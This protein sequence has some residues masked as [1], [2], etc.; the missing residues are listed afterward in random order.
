MRVCLGIIFLFQN[1]LPAQ[2]HSLDSLVASTAEPIAAICGD[3]Q[4]VDELLRQ[5]RVLSE[6]A[7]SGS[8]ETLADLACTR[9]RLY[10]T[11]TIARE[12]WNMPSGTSWHEGA[13][14]AT[15]AAL[16]RGASATPI[17]ELLGHLLLAEPKVDSQLTTVG[18]LRDRM[19]GGALLGSA[20][21]RG[22]VVTAARLAAWDDLERCALHG[23]Q[24][25]Q[26]STWLL[27]EVARSAFAQND[28]AGGRRFFDRAIGSARTPADW[29]AIGWHLGW[30]LEPEE[31]EAWITLADSARTAWVRDR[32]ASRDIRDGRN[33]DTRI[34]E[35]FRRLRVAD[36]A[37]R[38]T[39]PTRLLARFENAATPENLPEPADP[40]YIQLFPHG[41]RV[42]EAWYDP[43]L[44]AA[45]PFRNHRR[46]DPRYD[47]RAAV[48]L[49]MGPPVKRI[50]WA[51]RDTTRVVGRATL[52]QQ[53]QARRV[54]SPAGSMGGAVGPVEL[55]SPNA[56]I[57]REAWTY[58]IDG[59]ELLLHFEGER[60]T[61]TTEATRLV[62][63][64][65]GHYLCDIDTTRCHLSLRSQGAFEQFWRLDPR[66]QQRPPEL[67]PVPPE[68]IATIREA[69]REHLTQATT[70][71]DHGVRAARS[72]TTLARLH[73]VWDPASGEV[74]GVV[75]YAVRTGDV[76]E[77]GD[78][79]TTFTLT[80]RQWD[81]GTGAWLEAAIPRA[82]RLP[83][84]RPRDG[85]LTGH[86]VVA[87]GAGV[88][89]W[90]VVA[91][92]DTTAWGRAWADR[93]APLG[94]GALVISDVILGATSQGQRWRTTG[95]TEVPLAPLGAFD[96]NEPMTLYWQVKSTTARDDLRT[97]V[98]LYE[99][100]NK[101]EEPALQIAF[102]GRVAAGLTEELREVGIAR[103]D[104]GR[105]R[106][107]VVLTD[108]SDGA[109]VRRSGQLLVK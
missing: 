38:Y 77:R 109:T 105:Y 96:R 51:G 69:D 44:V 29:E 34:E 91:A 87:S 100:G 53:A 41:V 73:R 24:Q 72:I 98:A 101:S 49:R 58:E 21:V 48:W 28:G 108:P 94:G 92:Q 107:E 16:T 104:G 45:E 75:P 70:K 10:L 84:D 23:L 20:A 35:H 85:Y 78:T 6:R 52:D 7:P 42:M 56:T 19:D 65:L 59:R 26:D 37:F 81:P 12:S 79:T 80:V 54:N 90:S 97:T 27:I 50:Q 11:G 15:H 76:A 83:R 82:L 57:T 3:R 61:G 2:R 60:F 89:A 86:A 9:A 22:C 39:I 103:L 102:T 40:R 25:G 32:L 55:R 18:L 5:E 14:R 95:G 33:A 66:S 88:S 30:F 106:V 47:D 4:S 93:T 17:A 68:T 36:A 43:G 31:A 74:L 46:Y 8:A 71:D 64:V 99:T 1:D 62:T 63:G 67:R 13:V